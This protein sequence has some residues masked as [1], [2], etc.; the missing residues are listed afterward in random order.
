VLR[1]HEEIL[2]EKEGVRPAGAIEKKFLG[3][4]KTE[5]L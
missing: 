2:Q 3:L 1:H 4:L 5:R